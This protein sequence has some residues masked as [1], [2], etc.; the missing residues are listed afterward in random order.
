MT[1]TEKIANLGAV[2]V[3][4]AAVLAA[5]PLLWN[6]LVGLDATSRCWPRCTC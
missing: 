5:I 6:S 1:R 2:V 4:F 3:P